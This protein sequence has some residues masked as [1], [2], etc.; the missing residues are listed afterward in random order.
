MTENWHYNSV[1]D[2]RYV[3][4]SWPKYGK[5]LMLR[6]IVTDCDML[7]EIF[8]FQYMSIKRLSNA[9]IGTILAGRQA[10]E[11]VVRGCKV[12]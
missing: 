3:Q 1:Q 12:P 10:V 5:M 4:L 2:Y 11:A 7:H 8:D 6:H 9:T